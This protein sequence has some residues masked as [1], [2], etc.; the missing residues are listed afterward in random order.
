ML[1]VCILYVGVTVGIRAGRILD[2]A[3]EYFKCFPSVHIR[4]LA[5]ELNVMFMVLSLINLIPF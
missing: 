4:N 2:L 3:M 1:D 5:I